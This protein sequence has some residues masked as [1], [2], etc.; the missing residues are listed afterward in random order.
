[1]RSFHI[2]R[3]LIV[4]GLIS[5]GAGCAPKEPVPRP[6][7]KTGRYSQVIMAASQLKWSDHQAE[8]FQ[9]IAMKTDLTEHDQFY[10]INAVLHGGDSDDQAYTL[11]LLV[12]NPCLTDKARSYIVQNLHRIYFSS[13]RKVVVQA[14]INYPAGCHTYSPPQ[15]ESESP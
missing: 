13:D 5:S 2:I 8:T 7:G 6:A 15:E 1:M 12:A 4:M 10:L 9:M 3:A 14:L 11:A